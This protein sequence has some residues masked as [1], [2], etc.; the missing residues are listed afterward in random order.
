MG[1][2]FYTVIIPRIKKICFA[3]EWNSGIAKDG[4]GISQIFKYCELEQYE[5]TLR[6]LRN[7][8]YKDTQPA[9][10]YDK[11]KT[12]E[13]Y[14]FSADNKFSDVINIEVNS[15]DFDINFDNL[16]PNIDFPET[17]SNIF[18]LPIKRI[19]SSNVELIDGEEVK[20]INYDYRNMNSNEKLDFLR[21]LKPL[22][23]WGKDE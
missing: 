1:N 9:D 10:I 17:I 13:R 2:Y 15:E 20:V 23:W 19:T 5:D 8:K 16:Y 4:N 22:L 12:F 21:L 6:N 7:M 18:G 11:S 3:S 14:I